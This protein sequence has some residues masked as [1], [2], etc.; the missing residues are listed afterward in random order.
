MRLRSMALAILLI[1]P[2]MAWGEDEPFHAG[3][4]R[5]AVAADVPFDTLVW[6]PTKVTESPWQVGPFLLPAG[7]GAT[8]ADG[9]RPIVLLSHGGGARCGNPLILSGISAALARQGFVVVAPFHG[10]AA[11]SLRPLEIRLA[12]DAVLGDP[13]FGPHVDPSRL[14]RIGFSLGGAVTLE[15][16]GAVP[17]WSYLTAYC[18]DHPDDVMSCDHAPPGSRRTGHPVAP[19]ALPSKAIVLLD[20]FAVPFQRA[21][22]TG[23]TMPVLLFR[24]DRSAL[25]ADGNALALAAALPHPPRYETV[26]GGHFVFTDVCAP[27]LLAAEPELCRDPPGV[28]RAA[29]HPGVA[30]KI[31]AFFRD[32]L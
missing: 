6:Y 25:P 22:L 27:A 10:T 13:R 28:D 2:A 23:V 31:A 30:A 8:V 32:S 14:G 20:P 12:L 7:P 5:L 9:R 17:D 29:V 1:T 16:A 19:S 26:A 15:L 24:P 4:E 18:A 3:V 11:L 21:G